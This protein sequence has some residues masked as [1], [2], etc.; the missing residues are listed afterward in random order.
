ME[1]PTDATTDDSPPAKPA[2]PFA[3]PDQTD[4]ELAAQ[5]K[6]ARRKIAIWG[7]ATGGLMAL[8]V[9]LCIGLLVAAQNS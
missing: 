8:L 2:N 3:V 6:N 9:L 5:R 1:T 7:V 4:D